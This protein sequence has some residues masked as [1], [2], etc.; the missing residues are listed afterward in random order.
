MK[1]INKFL[2]CIL[3][4]GL[5]ASVTACG[6]KTDGSYDDK[7]NNI[8]IQAYTGGVGVE[9]LNAVVDEFNK[10]YDSAVSSEK[11]VM[12]ILT[13]NNKDDGANF[14]EAFKSGTSTADIYFTSNPTMW[15]EMISNNYLLDLSDVYASKPDGES[16][17]TVSQKLA[18]ADAN[19]NKLYTNDGEASGVYGLP[20]AELFA[21]MVVNKEVFVKN[22][23]FTAA[24][25]SEKE[26]IEQELNCSLKTATY[27]MR[28]VLVRSDVT[29]A[30]KYSDIILTAGKDG[31]YGTVDDG[32]PVNMTEW[33]N[34]MDAISNANYKAFLWAGKYPEYTNHVLSDV[35][36]QY[37]GEEDMKKWLSFGD[38]EWS[39]TDGSGNQVTVNTKN[40]AESFKVPEL[41]KSLEFL[42]SQLVKNAYSKSITANDTHTDTQGYFIYGENSSTMEKAAIL[43]D[44]SWWENEAKSKLKGINAYNV[45]EYT[46]LFAPTF[47]GQ[48]MAATDSYM[49]VTESGSVFARNTTDQAKAAKIKEFLS[50]TCSDKYLKHFTLTTGCI[51]PYDYSLTSEESAQLTPFG[52]NCWEIY[53]SENV[54]LVK[55]ALLLNVGKSNVGMNGEYKSYIDSNL[56]EAPIS[57]LIKNISAEKVFDGMYTYE[58]GNIK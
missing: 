4:L 13:T 18:N 36:G 21:G 29:G 41:K 43:C 57:A 53:N 12:N 22:G 2:S 31:K 44:G 54:H 3:A 35:F 47:E 52:R 5:T 30:P 24:D 38:E 50:M 26:A 17:K 51:R 1:K 20:Y 7:A 28:T 9:W 33:N 8:Y 55:T 25:V 16:G 56:Y 49:T 48:K 39:F 40:R 27:Q 46:F 34:M 58:K 15:S 14:Y 6:P 19:Y 23:W 45:N 10:K 32:Q 37:M 11:W 42:S